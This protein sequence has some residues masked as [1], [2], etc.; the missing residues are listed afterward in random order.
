MTDEK[1]H[2]AKC[3]GDLTHFENKGSL[4]FELDRSRARVTVQ[5]RDAIGIGAE[6]ARDEYSEAA[7]AAADYEATRYGVFLRLRR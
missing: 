7:F 6:W 1:L 5:L 2:T 3:L 4:P